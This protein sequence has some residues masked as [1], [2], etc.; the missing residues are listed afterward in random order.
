MHLRQVHATSCR[1]HLR[2]VSHPL[3]RGDAMAL[4]RAEELLNKTWTGDRQLLKLS[5]L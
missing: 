1:S 5:S 2:Q 3:A 4:S